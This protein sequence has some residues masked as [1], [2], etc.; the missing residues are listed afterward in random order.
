MILHVNMNAF[1]VSVEELGRPELVGK[2]TVITDTPESRGV[3]AED[4]FD[5]EFRVQR[6]YLPEV[7]TQMQ[8]GFPCV[9]AVCSTP[10][11]RP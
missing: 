7:A 11:D 9:S 2:P 5:P 4:P 10:F 1:H 3:S 6:V 8:M